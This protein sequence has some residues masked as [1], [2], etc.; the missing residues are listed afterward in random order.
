MDGVCIHKI[1]PAN[2]DDTRGETWTCI[3]PALQT[4]VCRRKI[5][6]VS[7]HY[8]K[9]DDSSKNPE[10]LFIAF[11]KV[12]FTFLNAGTGEKEVVAV[13]AGTAVS[14]D[15]NIIHRTRILEYAVILEFRTTVFDPAAPDTYQSR[16]D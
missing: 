6:S 14:I 9:G 1:A 13:G 8:H 2:P 7:C 11:G 16:I 5:G 10:Q 3:A 4:V 12:E 15:P